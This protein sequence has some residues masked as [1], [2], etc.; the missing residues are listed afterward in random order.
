MC[1]L[2]VLG[3]SDESGNDKGFHESFKEN[4]K[5]LDEESYSTRLPW[6]SNHCPLPTNKNLALARLHSATSK[7]EKLK[8]LE[9]CHEIITDQVKE[10]ILEEI[11]KEPTGDVTHYVLHQPVIREEA[12]STCM[13]IVYDCSARASNRVPSLND[14]LETGPPLQP[15]IFDILLRN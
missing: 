6:K 5:R 9:E 14:C 11:P 10:G 8:K 13:R 2:E 1:L 3:L 12:E 15:R 7:L 4:L